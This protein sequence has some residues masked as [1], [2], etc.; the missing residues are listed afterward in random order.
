M[1]RSSRQKTKHAQE[2]QPTSRKL[3]KISE[4]LQKMLDRFPA[5]GQ[6]STSE[7]EDWYRDLSP[8]SEAAIDFAFEKM[9]MGLFFP[10]NGQVI[11]L[12]MS[13]EPPDAPNV[14]STVRCD[15]TCRAR[16]GKGYN[17][18]DMKWLFRRMQQ[19][20][21]TGD[22]P[23]SEALLTELDSRRPDGAPEWRR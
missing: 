22:T 17:E 6:I 8:Y 15:A 16:H 12:C 1:P 3:D 18:N 9:R 14:V 21:A 19:I 2:I 5:K 23:D 7:I 4:W 13:Y 11:D 20:Y 10:M